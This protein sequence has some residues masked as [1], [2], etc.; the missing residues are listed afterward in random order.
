MGAGQSGEGRFDVRQL[1]CAEKAGPAT[2]AT[3]APG[4]GDIGVRG[5]VVVVTSGRGMA[6]LGFGRRLTD[7][8]VAAR[9]GEGAATTVCFVFPTR[10]GP[11]ALAGPWTPGTGK[12]AAPG[13]AGGGLWVGPEGWKKKAPPTDSTGFLDLFAAFSGWSL[14]TRFRRRA[15]A[16]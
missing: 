11:S 8:A 4:F 9:S 13:I 3:V 7:E 6:P 10:G 15:R 16:A 1:E 2:G 5:R 12:S 14:P